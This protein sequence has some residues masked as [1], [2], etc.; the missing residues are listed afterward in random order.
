MKQQQAAQEQSYDS[1]HVHH[2]RQQRAPRD[3]STQHDQ[4]EQQQQQPQSARGQPRVNQRGRGGARG[5]R[6]GGRSG[7]NA[8]TAYSDAAP[9]ADSVSSPAGLP[10]S[11]PS[12]SSSAGGASA[13]ASASGAPRARR[14]P[15]PPHVDN[16]L[17]AKSLTDQLQS[18]SYEC[19]VC[20][21]VVGRRSR[22][23][24]CDCCHVILH[25]QCIQQWYESNRSANLGDPSWRCPGCQFV[26]TDPPGDYVC[27]CGKMVE[28]EP[29]PFLT[30]HSCGQ[31]CGKKRNCGKHECNLPCHPGH[32]ARCTQPGPVV[33]CACGATE[34][35]LKCGEEDLAR[36][37]CDGVC[38]KLLA[39]G[40]HRCAARCHNGACAP[41]AD[42]QLLRC[43]CG[44]VEEERVCGQA[45][46]VADPL[47][48]E[49]STFSCARP[50]NKELNCG[51][52]RCEARCHAGPCNPCVRMPPSAAGEVQRCGCGKEAHTRSEIDS[53][54][55]LAEWKRASC[56]ERLPSCGAKCGKLLNC[57]FHTCTLS[58]HDP[59]VPCSNSPSG[60]GGGVAGCAEVVKRQCRCPAGNI[61]DVACVLIRGDR[62]RGLP[63]AGDAAV[64]CET[65]CRVKLACKK[66]VCGQVCCPRGESHVCTRIC[67]KPLD[68]GHHTCDSHCHVG[69][70][71]PCRVVYRD[72]VVCA[73]GRTASAR[74][75][76]CGSVPPACPFPC[77]RVRPCGH[78]CV[79]TCHEKE[80]PPCVALVA[81]T[82]AGGH[83][84][85]LSVPCFS[86][87]SC[88]VTCNKLLRCGTHHCK[89]PCHAGRC[90]VPAGSLMGGVAAAA[91]AAA[92]GR[93]GW[94]M[95]PSAAAAAAAAP[96]RKEEDASA[97]AAA[98]AAA[99]VAA[100]DESSV[101]SCAQRCGLKRPDCG[102][103]CA[104]VCHPGDPCPTDTPCREP[105][106]IYCECKRISKVV[107]C[108][109]VAAG[110]PRALECPPQCEI[111]ARNARFRDALQ[112]DDSSVP[113]I[114]YPSEVL[115]QV[116][117]GDLFDFALRME[118][119]LSEFVAQSQR[120]SH[121]FLPMQTHQ[122]WL[123]HQLATYWNV[124]SESFDPEPRRTVRVVKTPHSKAPSMKLTDAVK[125]YREAKNNKSGVALGG[126][127]L[128]RVMA[129]STVV[130]L[131]DLDQDP[132][133]S[134][135]DLALALRP[136]SVDSSGARSFHLR[137]NWLDH[138]HALV[139][140]ADAQQAS[141][142]RA[143]LVS[144][145]LFATDPDEATSRRAV[146]AWRET[147]ASANNALFRRRH[148]TGGVASIKKLAPPAAATTAGDQAGSFDDWSTARAA[149]GSSSSTGVRG[150]DGPAAAASSSLASP[151]SSWDS[152]AADFDAQLEAAKRAS[153][154]PSS[155]TS[156]DSAVLSLP[157]SAGSV[158][159]SKPGA[160]VVSTANAWSALNA[161]DSA[162]VAAGEG[163]AERGEYAAAAASSSADDEEGGW[164]RA[165]SSRPRRQ[166]K[167]AAAQAAPSV[168]AAPAH[169]DAFDD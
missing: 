34:H 47:E 4:S 23:W 117:S 110:G 146:N 35:R 53:S 118:R 163:A 20:C 1:Q 100:E 80:C 139:V 78:K 57:S 134:P 115:E 141:S 10:A 99:A 169:R 62:E 127:A 28:P 133:I 72:G 22:I 143:G 26:R 41:C 103:A 51:K 56:T 18:N 158:V 157:S 11:S 138:S 166:Q 159:L 122:R 13:S 58:C 144:R 149:T 98:A 114:P 60:G 32:C 2:S 9:L 8:V 153:L 129:A 30:P 65:K 42:V 79:H 49:R 167:Q 82:C 140:C 106:R 88:G 84:T 92:D 91:A 85:L 63:P 40:K 64:L 14:S 135:A 67:E 77:S 119:V 7:S 148:E 24:S 162:V 161:D 155:N 17:L 160:A 46:V 156:G 43:F 142:V 15:P 123:L 48:P 74:N 101:R 5:G 38:N 109:S 70:C 66:H 165:T 151:P 36:P 89:R 54:V 136:Y 107:N 3:S 76:K 21:S 131:F 25:L 116:I 111:D 164:E 121:T 19:S 39:C 86:T 27:F 95:L 96:E 68:C 59:S 93:R 168:V 97:A 105:A 112:L 113:R 94:G 145:K 6:G 83:K 120:P 108:S 71:G 154:L 147:H 31:V 33:T 52:H 44:Q 126:I 69:P 37:T 75:F 50:C 104:A 16:S 130:H 102:H 150:S 12:A 55:S 137:V 81:K 90:V 125:L 132:K 61:I 152:H 73:C 124:D 45:G 29:Q 128:P 87:P